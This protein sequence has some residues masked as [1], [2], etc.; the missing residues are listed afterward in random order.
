MFLR[1]SMTFLSERAPLMAGNT[2]MDLLNRVLITSS[3]NMLD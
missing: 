2:Y 1:R 3:V